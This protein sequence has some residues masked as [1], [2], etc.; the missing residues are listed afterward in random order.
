MD[1]S[2]GVDPRDWEG[3]DV[4]EALVEAR[5][6]LEAVAASLPGGDTDVERFCSLLQ[7]VEKYI[8]Q[9]ERRGAVAQHLA[10]VADILTVAVALAELINGFAG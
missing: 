9:Q 7:E 8:V 3:Q 10:T 6:L 5:C 1:G 2:M 4:R